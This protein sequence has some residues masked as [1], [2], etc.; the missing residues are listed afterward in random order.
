MRVFDNVIVGNMTP[1]F[2][3]EGNIVATVPT[4]SGVI[5]MANRDVEVFDNVFDNNGTANVMITGYRYGATPAGYSPLPVRV[6][7]ADKV[8]GR[9]GLAPGPQVPGG[10]SLAQA[11]GGS[12]PPVLWDGSG[13]EIRVHDQVAVLSLGL[14]DI[15]LPRSAATP[16]PVDLSAPAGWARLPGVTLPASM[17]AAAN[18]P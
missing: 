9:A 8:H 18:A 5:V 15:A 7:V 1:N 12:I 11:F 14:S 10:E 17:E 4:G 13:S 16:A 6:L 2:A 3:P